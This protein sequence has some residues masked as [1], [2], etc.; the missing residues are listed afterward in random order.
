MLLKSMRYFCQRRNVTAIAA[1]GLALGLAVGSGPASAWSLADAAKPYA[2]TTILCAGDGY[3]PMEAYQKVSG[4][5]TKITGIEVKWD[6]ASLELLMQ[7]MTADVLNNTGI[8]DC[9]QLESTAIG[10]WLAQDFVVP[11]YEFLDDP[12]LRDPSFD[13]STAFIPELFEHTSMYEGKI[14]GLP[15][16]FIPRFMVSRSDLANHAG[17]QAAFKAKYGYEM[18]AVPDTW[19]QYFDVSQFFTRKAGEKLGDETLSEDFYGTSLA[20]ARHLAIRYDFE[21]FLYGFGGSW[22]DADGKV[23]IDSDVAIEALDFWLSMRPNMSPA[24][25]E[26]TWDNTYSDM[27]EGRAYT[28]PT[29]P[30]T[31]PYLEDPEGCPKIAGNLTYGPVPGTHQTVADGQAWLIPRSSKNKEA[32]F[33]YLQWLSSFDVQRECQKFGCTSTRK[34]VWFEPE[35]DDVLAAQMNRVL[36]NEG[37]LSVRAKSPALAKMTDFL[38]D[39]IHAAALGEKSAAEALHTV[40]DKSRAMLNQ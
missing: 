10:L 37:Y 3:A 34:D 7:K 2:G 9:A 18:P 6:V 40:G 38:I 20:L 19:Q 31:T 29:W 15:Y 39:E 8:F 25:L 30:D 36:M 5:F 23:A 17:E 1:C 4:E 13:P 27:C 14:W 11:M 22:F 24:Y 21:F 26:Y 28:Y 16:H 12:K 33:L 32:T 35:F